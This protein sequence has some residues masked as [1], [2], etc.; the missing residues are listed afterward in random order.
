MKF[1]GL[2]RSEG[3]LDTCGLYL[4]AGPEHLIEVTMEDVDVDCN[5]GLVMVDDYFITLLAFTA[6]SL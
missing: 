4:V 5:D 3:E 6:Y 2:C 1:W